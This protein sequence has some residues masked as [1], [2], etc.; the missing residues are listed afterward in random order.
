MQSPWPA[1]LLSLVVLMAV[2]VGYV[3]GT[4]RSADPNPKVCLRS[5]EKVMTRCFNDLR[6]NA[7]NNAKP[8]LSK[9]ATDE[10]A[11]RCLELADGCVS[12]CGVKL[13]EPLAEEPTFSEQLWPIPWR[14]P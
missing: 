4:Y 9:E 11:L 8:L 14:A 5:C 1:V 7:H 10:V 12:M 13:E 6:Y 2:S 3:A